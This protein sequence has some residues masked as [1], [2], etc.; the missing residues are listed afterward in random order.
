MRAHHDIKNRAALL[1]RPPLN[2][3][4]SMENELHDIHAQ[5]RVGHGDVHV[6]RMS[7]AEE[8]KAM[9]VRDLRLIAS[10]MGDNNE[11]FPTDFHTTSWSYGCGSTSISLLAKEALQKLSAGVCVS[12]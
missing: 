10:D 6:R 3:S 9:S 12:C 5:L 2:A 7:P 8:S 4:Q 1:G 11:V